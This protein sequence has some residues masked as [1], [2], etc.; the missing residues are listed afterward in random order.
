[1]TLLAATLGLAAGVYEGV[2]LRLTPRI[3]G[4]QQPDV[5]NMICFLAPLAVCLGFA[6]LG[7][8]VGIIASRLKSPFASKLGIA[9]LWGAVG[10][11]LAASVGL[12]QAASG[13]FVRRHETVRIA[14]GF[15]VVFAWALLAMWILSHMKKSKLAS[16]LSF[17]LKPWALT[18]LLTLVVAAAGVVI[19][20]YRTPTIPSSPDAEPP[21]VWA[22]PNVVLITWD[23]VRADHLS[24][25]GYSRPTTPNLDRLAAQGVLF[26]NAVSPS[27]WTLPTFATI[28]TGLLPHQHGANVAVPLEKGPRTLAEILS[29]RGYETAGFNANSYNGLAGWGTARGFETYFDAGLTFRHNLATT[30]L[31]RAILQ[32]AYETFIRYNSFDRTDAEQL[33][34]EVYR[35]HRYRSKRPY[36]L[37]VNYMDAHSPYSVPEP[38]NHRFGR[39]RK[40]LLRQMASLERGR[41]AQPPTPEDRQSLI[42]AYDNGL[43]YLDAQFGE[44]L[45]FLA[46]QPEWSNTY[47]IVTSDHGDSF[48]EH[49]TYQHGWNLYRELLHVPLVVYGP[50]VP[51]GMHISYL[52]RTRELFSTILDLSAQPSAILRRTTLRRF[53]RPGFE[54][55]PYDE[56]TIAEL[57]SYDPAHPRHGCISLMTPQW[58]YIHFTA[59]KAELYRWPLDPLEQDNLANSP[60]G[61]IVAQELRD[62]LYEHI[63]RSRRPWR[64][65]AYLIALDG[66]S[67]S[68]LQEAQ[69]GSS[70]DTTHL[71]L[72]PPA[73][74][75][76][77]FFGHE[78]SNAGLRPEQ[79]DEELV[80]S[81][82]YE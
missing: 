38:F 33:N 15:L 27:S 75:S 6:P 40:S 67:Y 68:V 64:G 47:V 81:I 61:Q 2:F 72:N 39:A 21:G 9:L 26:E 58:H 46:G 30:V 31:S 24:A 76:Q 10:A 20:S 16:L 41:F 82:P 13:W 29:A 5:N 7:L 56:A 45:K 34:R 77:A 48:G 55:Q 66:P 62:R 22:Q 4:L 80:K 17:P 59:G 28:F 49:G 37:F 74:S 70:S 11:Y 57:T 19:T 3:A 12:L 60:E 51:A 25:Y 50:G 53:W 54:P 78:P 32:P 35:W 42:D 52:A 8:A 73:G 43:A 44:L 23:T 36:F 69:R 1:M 18:L 65:L 63:G 79:L 71:L 14:A